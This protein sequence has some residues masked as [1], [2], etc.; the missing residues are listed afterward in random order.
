MKTMDFDAIFKK[1]N[2]SM[3]EVRKEKEETASKIK[4]LIEEKIEL[5]RAMR[6]GQEAMKKHIKVEIELRETMCEYL[7]CKNEMSQ[8]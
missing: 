5:E 3:S 6:E 4:Y 2:N 1:L 7:G 8:L